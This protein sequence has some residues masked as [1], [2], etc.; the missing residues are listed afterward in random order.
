[1]QEYGPQR[2][3]QTTSKESLGAAGNKRPR[4]LGFWNSLQKTSS[5]GL[6]LV[7]EM[8]MTFNNTTNNSLRTRIQQCCLAAEKALPQMRCVTKSFTASD[9][10]QATKGVKYSPRREGVPN[11]T[12]L[13]RLYPAAPR[14]V[15]CRLSTWLGVEERCVY[16]C[17]VATPT[18]W[19]PN[20]HHHHLSIVLRSHSLCHYDYII[21]KPKLSDVDA[22]SNPEALPTQ[23]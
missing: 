6:Q 14:E 17:G 13:G 23:R 20:V 9:L 21:S 1:S 16:R 12:T 4:T 3:E 19:N 10:F 5:S 22:R 11:S 15:S 7:E 18:P 8:M 2:G